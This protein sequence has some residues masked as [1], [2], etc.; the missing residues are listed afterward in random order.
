MNYVI[1]WKEG[2]SILEDGKLLQCK[3]KKSAIKFWLNSESVKIVGRYFIIFFGDGTIYDDIL[4]RKLKE[5]S[6]WRHDYPQ[7]SGD[8]SAIKKYVKIRTKN[9]KANLHSRPA[10]IR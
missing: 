1:V 10:Q 9:E 5:K 8:L 4:Y 3:R 6:P 7:L 2:A